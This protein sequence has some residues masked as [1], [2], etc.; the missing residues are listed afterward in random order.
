ML[1]KRA[2]INNPEENDST[3]KKSAS[4]HPVE[5]DLNFGVK[6]A[7]AQGLKFMIGGL[8]CSFFFRRLAWMHDIYFD[9]PAAS[10]AR[11]WCNFLQFWRMLFFCARALKRICRLRPKQGQANPQ[12]SNFS[13]CCRKKELVMVIAMSAKNMLQ[14]FSPRLQSQSF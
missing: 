10:N 9:I 13:L 3:Q 8:F 11:S 12:S 2:K 7:R 6:M 4:V 14:L 5:N 1:G